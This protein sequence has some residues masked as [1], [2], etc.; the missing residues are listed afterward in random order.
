MSEARSE[1]DPATLGEVD[2]V[3]VVE[4][5]AS[6][7][8]TAPPRLLSALVRDAATREVSLTDPEDVERIASLWRAL[9]PADEARCHIPRFG[10]RFFRDDGVVAEASLCWE[11][12]NAY[13]RVPSEPMRF[14]FDASAPAAVLLLMQVRHVLGVSK[15]SA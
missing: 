2:A 5:D 12:N 3:A 1:Y 8:R 10:L 9:R 14:T 15:G 7:R 6:A 11:C 4:L 13:G